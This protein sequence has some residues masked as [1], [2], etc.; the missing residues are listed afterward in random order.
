MTDRIS[1]DDLYELTTIS[2][3]ALSPSG[4]RVAFVEETFSH[5]DDSRTRTLYLAPTDGSC[6]PSRITRFSEVWSPQWSSDGQFLAFLAS[7]N[8]G[9]EAGVT[10]TT[11][12]ADGEATAEAQ[13]WVLDLERGGEAKRVTAFKEGVQQF[14]W[15]P[16]GDR[17]VVA[18]RDPTEVEAEYLE[19]REDGGPIVT[20]RLQHK[21]DGT[22]YL[23]T[24]RT[25][26]F[27]VDV[28]SRETN[29]LDDAYAGMGPFAT[30]IGASPAWSP[31]GA[32][33]AF[34]SCRV[35][36]PDDSHVLDLYTIR[37]DG[38]NLTQIT[39]SDRTVITLS[40][41]PDGK[42]LAYVAQDLEN[43]YQPS[44]VVVS[45][46]QSGVDRTVS[47]GLDRHIE[48][49]AALQWQD[50]ETIL[51]RIADAGSS[52]LARFD[53]DESLPERLAN[54]Q[55]GY[56]TIDA[57]DVTG[58][59]V[60]VLLTHPQKGADIYVLGGEA[61]RGLTS[62]S[63]DRTRLTRTND[64]LLDRYEPPQCER[65]HYKNGN[66]DTVEAIAALPPGYDTDDPTPSPLIV[67]IHGGPIWHASPR[68]SFEDMFWTHRGYVVL[69]PNYR[70][71]TSYGRAFSEAIAGD[72][73]P[74]EVEDVVA[75]VDELVDRG[76]TDPNR[77]F[78][79]GFSYGG[80]TTAWLL[81]WTDRFTAGAAEHGVYDFASA[82]GTD[83]SHK[84]AEVDYGLP[85]ENP[86][87][88]DRMSSLSDVDAIDAPLLI[89]AGGEDH[90]C[91]PSQA[92]QLYVS[93]KKRG[94]PSRLVLYPTENHCRLSGIDDPTIPI[95]RLGQLESWFDRFDPAT[96][97]AESRT[98]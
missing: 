19:E 71:S 24:V 63:I 57:F 67:H 69:H 78:A 91:P 16:D 6:A 64:E 60:A 15:A 18:A 5:A 54:W 17:I 36:N 75:G 29:R 13:V 45:D 93:L 72:W 88:Y 97:Q 96:E 94:I 43:W 68:F 49:G 38:T 81:A 86:A 56:E 46:L 44:D 58:D 50:E 42:R 85:W 83:D 41:N 22:G 80:I 61:P 77:V 59:T 76:W 11:S 62:S 27:V 87:A 20:E 39:D 55:D 66:G 10:A 51:T 25:Y 47:E 33:I 70:G 21:F 40:W 95:H 30:E 74:R 37:P 48:G 14:D 89:T 35:E 73:G 26:L 52:R 28:N 90:R 79:T 82:F 23:D 34:L 3:I 53:V 7:D 98:R 1:L 4:E 32:R 31:D 84:W 12:G 92:E 2:A 65:V 8:D 9:T